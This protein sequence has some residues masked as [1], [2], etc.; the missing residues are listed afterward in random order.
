MKGQKYTEAFYHTRRNIFH[1]MENRALEL[2]SGLVLR[3]N[4][5][6]NHSRLLC[7]MHLDIL[8]QIRLL[9][10]QYSTEDETNVNLMIKRV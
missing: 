1:A 4:A 2:A 3:Q 10:E 9:M 5:P 7:Y 8:S 6:H